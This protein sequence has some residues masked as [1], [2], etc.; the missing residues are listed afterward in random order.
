MKQ[1]VL[2]GTSL[3]VSRF[4]FGT[5]S[6]FTAGTPKE[7]QDLLAAA[8]EHGFRHFDTAPYY[9]Y[10][11]AERELAPLLAAHPDVTVTTKVGLYSPGGE[12]QS[13]AMIFARKAAGKFLPALSRP[14]VDLSVARARKA[15]DDSLKRLGRDHVELY[16]LHEPDI[17]MLDTDEWRT[18]LDSETRVGAFGLAGP[19]GRLYPFVKREDPLARVLQ[20]KDSMTQGEADYVLKSGRELQLTYGYASAAL[21][22]GAPGAAVEVI[23]CEALKR[24]TT[25]SILV[26]TRKVDRLAT[27]ARLAGH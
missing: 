7:R 22:G 13:D 21:A 15:L 17:A 9:G 14:T 11:V 12:N 26:S 2:P 23:L 10:G 4:T 16:L 25:G 18:W 20:A 27:Y 24:N 3:S 1:I 19:V 5:A 6:L 8:Y